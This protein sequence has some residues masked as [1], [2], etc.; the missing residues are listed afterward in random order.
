MDNEEQAPTH[1]AEQSEQDD[2]SVANLDE[3]TPAPAPRAKAEED[4]TLVES[5]ITLQLVEFLA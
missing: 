5:H 3:S 4:P 1:E 2:E